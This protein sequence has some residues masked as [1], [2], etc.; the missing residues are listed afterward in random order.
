MDR[1]KSSMSELTWDVPIVWELIDD[2]WVGHI[3]LP[4]TEPKEWIS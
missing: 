4:E 1:I 3:A 2:K